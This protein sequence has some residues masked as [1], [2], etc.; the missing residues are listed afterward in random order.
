MDIDTLE[1]QG[2]VKRLDKGLQ[3]ALGESYDL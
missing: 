1:A 2:R 3:D